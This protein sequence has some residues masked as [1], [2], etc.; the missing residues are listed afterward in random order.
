MAAAKLILP[1]LFCV[2]AVAG[3]TGARIQCSANQVAYRSACELPLAAMIREIALNTSSGNTEQALTQIQ[4]LNQNMQRYQ[5]DRSFT[6]ERFYHE[7]L[8]SPWE[9]EEAHAT[10]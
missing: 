1:V 7:V 9:S 3:Y 6:P 8:K 10:P 4:K 5:Q 2:G